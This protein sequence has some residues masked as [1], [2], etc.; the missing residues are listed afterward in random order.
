MMAPSLVQR[1]GLVSALGTGGSERI[2]SAMVR[3]IAQMTRGVDLRQAIDAPRI[4]TDNDGV[5]QLEP[6][7]PDDQVAN[8]PNRVPLVRAGLRLVGCMRCPAMDPRPPM[9]ARGGQTGRL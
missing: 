8:R 6:G 2:R 9:H 3:V 1:D 7:F 4:H 5:V